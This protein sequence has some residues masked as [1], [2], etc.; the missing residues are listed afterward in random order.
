MADFPTSPALLDWTSILSTT[1]LSSVTPVS[2]AAVPIGAGQYPF[3]PQALA[4]DFLVS[5]VENSAIGNLTITFQCSADNATWFTIPEYTFVVVAS[6][7]SSTGVPAKF[8]IPC[9]SRQWRYLR[10]QFQAQTAQSGGNESTVAVR[11][12]LVGVQKPWTK[13]Q[14]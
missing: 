9:M 14:G 1:L 2:T 7:A 13:V 4:V 12:A 3:E 5:T 8:T 10:A 11:A 6:T